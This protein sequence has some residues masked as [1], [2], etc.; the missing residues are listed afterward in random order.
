MQSFRNR[1]FVMAVM[2]CGVYGVRE[3]DKSANYVTVD[4]YLEGIEQSCYLEKI[5]GSGLT[6]HKTMTEHGPCDVVET[7]AATH[8]AYIG[9]DLKKATTYK[10]SYQ[11][12]VGSWQT[13]KLPE[14]V[15]ED[16]RALEIGE[17][18]PILMH[19]TDHAKIRK[20]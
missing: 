13:G 14:L 5:N 7:L 20:I 19:K 6:Q 15:H 12:P 16:G 10:V 18:T 2:F 1:I 9:Y 17:K 11:D 3:F 8:P 4:A